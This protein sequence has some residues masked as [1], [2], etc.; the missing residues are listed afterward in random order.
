M[1]RILT[2]SGWSVRRE[3]APW[4]IGLTTFGILALELTL[5]RWSSAQIRMFA[6]FSNVVLVCAFLGIGLGLAL[7]RK[8]PG[9]VHLVLPALVLLAVP[10]AFSERLGLV[11]MTF[12]DQSV[13]LWGAEVK[14]NASLFV[15]NLAI[16]LG[17]LALVST[18]FVGCGAALGHLFSRMDPLRAYQADLAGSLLGVLVFSAAAWLDTEPAVWLALGALPFAWLSRRAPGFVALGAIVWLGHH[19]VGDAIY[20]PYNR[21]DILKDD[22]GVQELRVNRDYHQYMYD[23]SDAKLATPQFTADYRHVLQ[24]TRD[25]YDLPFVVNSERGS[26][27]IVGAGTGNDVQ[28]ALRNG[29]RKVTSVDIDGR[30]IEVGRERH[31][32]APYRSASVTA[33]VDDARAFFEKN[34]GEKYDVVC[35]GLLD[36]HAMSS[37]MSVLRLDN[38]VYTEDGVRAA[39]GRVGPRGH[40]SLA[41]S[42]FAG[43]WFFERVYW[44]IARATGR[45]PI[46][47]YSPLFYGAMTFIVPK[48]EDP[49]LTGARTSRMTLTPTEPL[50]RTLT[51]SDDWPFLYLRPGVMPLGY[52]VVLGVILLGAA[53]SVRKVFGLGRPGSAF[54]WPLFFMGAAFL[55]IE[56]RGVTSLS[57][58]FGS[59]WVVNSVVFA[60]ILLMV[61]VAN[62]AVRRWQWGDPQPWFI[63]LLAASLLLYFFP[64]GWL[65]ALPLLARGLLG[66]LLTGLPIGIAGVIVPMLLSRAKDP[67]AAL[68][69]NLLGSVL[70]GT[71]EY[72]SMLGGLRATAL[73]AVIF[74]LVAFL[75][76]RRRATAAL[77]PA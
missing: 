11:A 68:G 48:A 74:Y 8:L 60:G 42:C 1:P 20:S 21:I 31:P 27:L 5:I 37:A 44:T 73:G 14:A 7:G 67:V 77:P 72:Y 39:W 18:V 13:M 26:A 49:L 41:I 38:F 36:S 19:S 43:R 58:L 71:F 56:T 17:L 23:L 35:F 59:T 45:E 10:I 12:P 76:L 62:T 15:R 40:L 9:L 24:L 66:G 51:T 52:L 65:H 75:L 70:G 61:L 69:S 63:P 50:E 25:L 16:F 3:S 47:F 30:I 28:A 64:I 2:D 6:Y 4:L 33:V 34:R 22:N 57:L 32:E 53:L 54:D 29:Y 55:L 46:A